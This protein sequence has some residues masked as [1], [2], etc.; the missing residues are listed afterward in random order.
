[1]GEDDRQDVP[2]IANVESIR[3]TIGF[4]PKGAS[5]RAQATACDACQ[6]FPSK[7]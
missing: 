2:F 1:V 3:M 6:C 5:S 7:S 4:G